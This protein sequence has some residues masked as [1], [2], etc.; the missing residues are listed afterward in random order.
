[1]SNITCKYCLG[2]IGS[3]E[4]CPECTG[5]RE[6][7]DRLKDA[8]QT[9]MTEQLAENTIKELNDLFPGDFDIMRCLA[10]K[11]LLKFLDDIGFKNVADAWRDADER[12]GFVTS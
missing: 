1:M 4:S 9:S 7:N 6:W 5:Y 10:D 8:K 11:I 12:I 2:I 3:S